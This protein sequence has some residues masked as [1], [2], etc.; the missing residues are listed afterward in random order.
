MKISLHISIK[1]PIIYQCLFPHYDL[2]F[3]HLTRRFSI[4]QNTLRLAR[5]AR[6]FQSSFWKVFIQGR[7]IRQHAWN[8]RPCGTVSTHKESFLLFCWVPLTML[9]TIFTI[10]CA[11]DLTSYHRNLHQL[12]R[13]NKI[14]EQNHNARR[15]ENF[16]NF[17]RFGT[18]T[19]FA[20][21]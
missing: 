19:K 5:N 16:K 1:D 11:Q 13:I 9:L 8:S 21:R 14:L 17:K 6:I 18:P 20:I 10:Q 12:A 3:F 15:R 4:I 7:N 2:L